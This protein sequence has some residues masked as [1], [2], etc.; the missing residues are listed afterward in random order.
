MLNKKKTAA[1]KNSSEAAGFSFHKKWP[2]DVVST[3]VCLSMGGVMEP[4]SHGAFD[5]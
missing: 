3:V 4:S 5:Q 2:S 1:E